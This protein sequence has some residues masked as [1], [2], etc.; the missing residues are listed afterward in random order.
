MTQIHWP[1][2]IYVIT[3]VGRKAALQNK[4]NISL[5]L[6]ASGSA[7]GD[8]LTAACPQGEI[9]E[10]GETHAISMNFHSSAL[11]NSAE[12]LTIKV[13]LLVSQWKGKEL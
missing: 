9:K 4:A 13:I 7:M 6:M 8:D 10:N 3:A 12:T 2:G 11:E 5:L 1:E